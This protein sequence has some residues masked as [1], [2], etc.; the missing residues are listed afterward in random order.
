MLMLI[1]FLTIL[2]F[3]DGLIVADLIANKTDA[4]KKEVVMWLLFWPYMLWRESKS[5]NRN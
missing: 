3:I 1:V 4:T 5:A 2:Y